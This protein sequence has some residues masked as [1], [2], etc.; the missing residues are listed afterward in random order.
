MSKKTLIAAAIA[1]ATLIGAS[2]GANAAP[3]SAATPAIATADA[4]Q[5]AGL[6]QEVGFKR[7]GRRFHRWHF[8][9]HF[10]GHRCGWLKYKAIKTD[11]RYWWHKYY[12]CKRFYYHF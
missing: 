10:H 12:K 5:S 6:I 8:K 11:S 1:A 7:R 3:L 9:R 2:A 4:G